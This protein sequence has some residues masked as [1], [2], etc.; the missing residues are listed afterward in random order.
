MTAT[1]PP[2]YANLPAAKP[3]AARGGPELRELRVRLEVVTPIM[4][5]SHQ[6]RA[7]DDVDVIRVPSVRGHLRFWWRALYAA[8]YANPTALYER[9][10]VLWGRA[11]N[12]DGGR[13]AVEIRGNVE[14]VGGTDSSEVRLFSSRDQQATPGAYALWPARAETAPRRR[15]GT[16]FQLTLKVPAADEAEVKNALRAWILFGGYGGRTRRGL[17][18]LKV[19]E[20]ASSWLPSAGTRQALTGLFGRDVFEPSTRTPC[21]VPWF[22]GA[23]IHVG[24]TDRNAQTAWTTALDWLKEFRQGTTGQQGSR[25]REPGTGK[26]Q[27]QRP[28]IS[29]WPEADKIRL[30]KN[31]T[32]AHA[33]RHNA[34][35]AWPRAGFGLPI[36]GQ[37]QKTDRNNNRNGYDEPGPFELRWRAGNVEHDRLASPLIVKALPLDDGTFAP[38]ALWLNRAHPTNGEVV[39]RNTNN[40][41]APFDRLVASGDT[42]RFSA[43][44][45]KTSLRQAFLDWLHSKYQTT[46]VAP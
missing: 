3:R 20:D 31:K 14:R 6:T 32:T 37:F 17:G 36:I 24:R 11:A 34:T 38:C 30:I 46:V 35:A 22:G 44:A 1:K 33:P 15:P 40:S 2:A 19:L 27:P 4:G 18:S 8:Q 29:N 43:L 10:S 39:L 21:D 5:G 13:S 12:D 25:A 7:I 9:E 45:N 23:A 42:A 28:S 41:Q 16:Q 26:A